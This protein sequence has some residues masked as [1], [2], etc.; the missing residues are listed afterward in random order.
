MLPI[1]SDIFKAYDIRGI[2]GTDFDNEMAYLLGLAFVELRKKDPDYQP[3]KKLKI[4]VGYDMRLSSSALKDNL[5]RGLITAGADAINLGL[6][7]TPT[8]YFA[9]A[10]YEYDG[11]VMVS[12]SHNPK[13]WNGF[14]LVRTKGVPVS[15]ETGINFVKEQ[16]MANHFLPANEPGQIL[17]NDSAFK[18]ELAYT[19]GLIDIK[20]IKNLKIVADAANGM[21]STYL[22]AIL[23]AIP[24]EAIPLNFKLDGTFPAHEAD[25]LKEENLKEL[26][27]A[28][29]EYKADLGISTDGDGDRIFFVDNEGEIISPAIIRGLL[30]QSF[31]ADK[32]GSKIGYD[33][34]PGKITPDLITAAGGIPVVTRVGHSLIKEQ[35]LKENI[36]FAGESSGHFFFNSPIGCFEFPSLMILKLLILFSASDKPIFEQLKQYRKYFL[37]GEINRTVADKD[38]VFKAIK[39]KYADGK[40]NELDGVSV[41]YPNFWFNVRGSNTEPKVRLNLEATSQEIMEQK[42]DEVLSLIK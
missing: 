23:S 37:S 24:G 20:K 14:K 12:A 10:K 38:S 4:A 6:V 39:E 1:N 27:K 5:I 18:D 34:R 31:L 28:I 26:Q 11:G 2:Y 21:G 32:P 42:R 13:E 7:S 8:F 25:P 41:E 35:M 30:A 33:I 17:F 3:G 29:I 19:W 15:G 9:V 22:E 16:I 36:Y 40:I